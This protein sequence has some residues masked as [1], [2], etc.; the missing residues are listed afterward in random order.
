MANLK[1]SFKG[2]ALLLD[3]WGTWCAPCLAEMPISKKLHEETI[4]L[5][6]EYTYL[7]TSNNSSIEKWKNKV[8]EL[9]IPRTHIFVDEKIENE[10]MRMFQASGYPSYRFIDSKGKY[11]LGATSRMKEMDKVKLKKLVEGK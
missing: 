11:K 10:L 8:A 3:F 6:L 4:D 2:K 1:S 9:S 5:P 7:C